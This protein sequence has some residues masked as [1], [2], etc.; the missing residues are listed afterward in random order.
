MKLSGVNT[1]LIEQYIA[2][3][4]NMG[5]ALSD[6]YTFKMFDD[7][8]IKNESTSVGLTKELADKWIEKRPN[9]SDVTRYKRINDIANFCIYL[10]QLG[11]Q[12]C[13]P[14]T[15]K[16][17]QSTFTPYIFSKEELKSFFT[18]CDTI[19]VHRNSN[20]KYILPVVFRVIYGCGLRI[21]EAL[22]LKNKDVNLDEG[23]IMVRETKNGSDRILP[24]SDSLITIC[25]QYN[26]HLSSNGS[27]DYFFIQWNG[28]RYAS[29][30]VYK[31]FRK[32]LWEAGISHGGKGLG[33]RVHDL[34]HSFSVHSL[35][36]MSRKGMDL[37]YSL[38]ILSKYL[39]HNSLEATDKYVR[40]TSDM[41]PELIQDVNKL[42]SYLFPEVKPNEA[43]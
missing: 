2:F 25:K 24:L 17:Y 10:N 18:A 29:D 38:P 16:K 26:L 7:F 35:A 4:R 39:G 43:H 40:L 36:E 22:S 30:T 20:M 32:I 28:S 34:R 33:P 27:E 8:T 41:Y 6:T 12:S 23:Y 5:Y 13:I 19:R 11:Y 9:E 14:R 1:Y 3:K 31:W 42:C 21:N 37:Y 15:P